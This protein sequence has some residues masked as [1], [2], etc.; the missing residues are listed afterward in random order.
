MLL[1]F[2]QLL[3]LTF[4]AAKFWKAINGLRFTPLNFDLTMPSC[5]I[6][7]FS[8]LRHVALRL[9]HFRLLLHLW[10][11][12]ALCVVSYPPHMTMWEYDRRWQAAGYAGPGRLHRQWSGRSCLYGPQ[13]G[14]TRKISSGKSVIFAAA[15]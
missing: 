2:Y 9:T 14:R 6:G 15:R 12:F 7:W 10:A 1:N 13:G 3:M 11:M 4:N 8:G 5:A